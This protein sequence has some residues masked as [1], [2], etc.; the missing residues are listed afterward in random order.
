MNKKN[1]RN[2]PSLTRHPTRTMAKSSRPARRPAHADPVQRKLQFV[3]NALKRYYNIWN[4]PMKLDAETAM[5]STEIGI[6]HYFIDRVLVQDKCLDAEARIVDCMAGAGTISLCLALHLP[7]AELHALEIDA[8]RV[9]LLEHNLMQAGKAVGKAEAE[10]VHESGKSVGN[11]DSELNLMQAASKDPKN[12]ETEHESSKDSNAEHNDAEN[13]DINE[14]NSPHATDDASRE[15]GPL[16]PAA[17]R[18]SPPPRSPGTR[19]A[20]WADFFTF[21]TDKPT[22][23]ADV[24]IFAPSWSEQERPSLLDILDFLAGPDA[25]HARCIVIKVAPG[26]EIA[27]ERLA[28]C[29][30]ATQHAIHFYDRHAFDFLV[31]DM[32]MEPASLSTSFENVQHRVRGATAVPLQLRRTTARP[33]CGMYTPPPAERRQSSAPDVAQVHCLAFSLVS[34]SLDANM[35]IDSH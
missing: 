15:P 27:P 1:K 30:R 5:M 11:S 3:R 34:V 2:T 12:V 19:T 24:L 35:R 26:T 4:F 10:P 28:F 9:V 20:H 21:F 32:R 29:T 14:V 33:R 16:T 18:L 7:R 31:L 22:D 13:K 6:L 8:A 25:P 17:A 23:W